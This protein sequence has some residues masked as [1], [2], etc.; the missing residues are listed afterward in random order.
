MFGYGPAY[1]LSGIAS[2]FLEAL[3]Q[4]KFGCHTSPLCHWHFQFKKIVIILSR[5]NEFLSCSTPRAWGHGNNRSPLNDL[6]MC[7]YTQ[8]SGSV[9]QEIED[10]TAR[11]RFKR[12]AR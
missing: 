6:L 11:L 3:L 7:L 1:P 9:Q 10:V 5:I 4:L 8:E 2:L 12:V